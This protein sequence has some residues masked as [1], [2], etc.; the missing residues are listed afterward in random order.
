MNNEQI[1]ELVSNKTF[2]LPNGLV[3]NLKEQP[4]DYT[5]IED[6][7]DCYGKVVQRNRHRYSGYGE[8]R[9]YEFDGKAEVIRTF[10]CEWWWQPPSDI[11]KE[12]IATM[13]STV[14]EILDWGFKT[15]VLEV[16]EGKDAYG[17][18]IVRDY[19]TLGGI[20]PLL[21]DDYTIDIVQDMVQ[22]LDMAVRD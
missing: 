11:T 2:D 15:L 6:F 16:C 9:P 19:T 13:R 18:D 21:D 3:L 7:V 14:R 1:K 17:K 8:Q 5:T 4:D 20:E 12:Q 22:D 10:D